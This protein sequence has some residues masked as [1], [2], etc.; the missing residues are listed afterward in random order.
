MILNNGDKYEV[1]RFDLDD[2]KSTYPNVDVESELNK[3]EAW[4]KANP[5][6]RKTLRGMPKFI[7][8][9]LNRANEKNA[10]TKRDLKEQET[11]KVSQEKEDQLVDTF[12]MHLHQIY[13]SKYDWAFNSPGSIELSK[14]KHRSKI[15]NFHPNELKAGLDK[16]ENL[17]NQGDPRYQECDPGKVLEL[18]KTTINASH[19]QFLLED[20]YTPLKEEEWDKNVSKIKEMFK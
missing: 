15:L 12:F 9:W 16:A 20:N 3:M 14:R 19:K 2:Y 1:P 6:R 7:N 11:Y 17:K 4:L 18:C 13:L 8:S 10:P 5:Q